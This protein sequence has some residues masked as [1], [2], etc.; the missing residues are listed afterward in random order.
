[1]EPVQLLKQLTRA[2]QAA[3]GFHI[4]WQRLAFSQGH[5]SEIPV[6]ETYFLDILSLNLS[7]NSALH[8]HSK[9]CLVFTRSL[10]KLISIEFAKYIELI[11][12]TCVWGVVLM[13]LCCCSLMCVGCVMGMD[14]AV[15]HVYKSRLP[16]ATKFLA[17]TMTS[18]AWFVEIE[19]LAIAEWCY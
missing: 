5:H 6:V 19:A 10:F 8:L 2:V 4:L 18:V 13:K 15:W 17:D 9:A 16:H 1:M 11:E 3:M 12:H 14:G 7:R